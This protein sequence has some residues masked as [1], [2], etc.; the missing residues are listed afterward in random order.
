MLDVFVT[1]DYTSIVMEFCDRGDL[2]DLR[3]QLAELSD[4]DVLGIV[5]QLSNGY[6]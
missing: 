4:N 1:G 3:K 2:S 6:R 5:K